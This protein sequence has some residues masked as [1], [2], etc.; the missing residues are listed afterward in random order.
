VLPA[1]EHGHLTCR[2]CGV[3]WEIEGAEGAALVDALRTSR[4]FSLDL[5]HLSVVGRCRDCTAEDEASDD[6]SA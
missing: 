1:R 4:G 6:P 3:T 2:G 5:S